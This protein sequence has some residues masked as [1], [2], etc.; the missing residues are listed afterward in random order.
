MKIE[1][2]N[3]MPPHT[4]LD[5]LF[6]VPALITIK[7]EHLHT[8]V[9]LVWPRDFSVERFGVSGTP[10]M[11]PLSLSSTGIGIA[12]PRQDRP[13]AGEGQS[14]DTF[15]LEGLTLH[16][17]APQRPRKSPVVVAEPAALPVN[18]GGAAFSA[19]NL[20]FDTIPFVL[21]RFR[22][23]KTLPSF[24]KQGSRKIWT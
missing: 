19:L 9:T 13:V 21:L 15:V 14:L 7:N 10:P 4:A 16:K 2:R 8:S 12:S 17:V 22:Q 3:T 20:H 18:A 24:R 1:G 5:W 11:K 23:Q 6:C